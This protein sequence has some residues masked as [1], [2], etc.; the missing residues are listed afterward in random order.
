MSDDA[1]CNFRHRDRTEVESNDYL[2]NLKNIVLTGHSAGGQYWNRFIAISDFEDQIKAQRNVS[3]HY[4]PMNPGAYLYLSNRRPVLTSMNTESNAS[5][6]N[7]LITSV[8]FA[9]P[10]APPP[11]YNDWGLGF[12]NIDTNTHPYVAQSG[13]LEA[14]KARCADRCVIY[15]I[16]GCDTE[17]SGSAAQALQE[18]MAKSRL[19]PNWI[20]GS[21]A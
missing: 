1:G 14:A 4:V 16:G 5:L 7:D 11:E 21:V 19:Q 13:G 20:G 2:P 18:W 3:V 6:C 17:V 9:F 12:S 10:V 15:L 8:P